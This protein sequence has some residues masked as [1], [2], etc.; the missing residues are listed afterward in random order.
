MK[1]NPIFVGLNIA[2]AKASPGDCNFLPGSWPPVPEFPICISSNGTV[3]SRYE[4]EEWDLTLW[5]GQVLK[6]NFGKPKRKNSTYISPENSSLFKLVIAYW[7]FGPNPVREIRTL[8]G[9]YENIRQ[10]FAYC[11]KSGISANDLYRFPK[12]VESLADNLYP[13]QSNRLL[14]LLHTLWE[15]REHVGISILDDTGI[16]LLRSKIQLHEKSQTAYIPPRIW[17]YQLS[18]LKEFLQDFEHH[19]KDIEACTNYCLHAYVTSAGDMESACTL[20]LPSYYKP[21]ASLN[22]PS[23]NGKLCG[24]QRFGPF[25]KTASRFNIL[26]LLEKWCGNIKSS[27][28]AVLSQYLS[29]A[30]HVGKAYLLNFTLMRIEEV[31][32]LRANCLVLETDKATNETIYLIKGATSKTVEDDQAYWITSPSSQ[33]AIKVMTW[34]SEFRTRCASFNKSLPLAHDDLTNPYLELRPSEPWRRQSRYDY[35]PVVRK[36]PVHYGNFNIKYPKLFDAKELMIQKADFDAALLV[37]PSLDAE[38]FAIGNVWPLSWHQLRRTG[39][40]NMSASGIVG[41]A[42]IQYQLKHVSRAMTRYYG[43]GFYHLD[44]RLNQE[45]SA[46]YVRGMYE[47]IA[48]NFAALGSSNFV[49][50]HGDKRKEQLVE[51][52]SSSSHAALI[53]AAKNGS[54]IYRDI[55]LGSCANPKPCPYGGIDYIGRCGGGDGKPACMDLLIDKNKKSQIQRLGELLS[56]R[57]KNTPEG[58]PLYVSIQYQQIAVGNILNV[59]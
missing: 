23:K 57:I 10:I 37:T 21:F 16:A 36:A 32:S 47:A 54:I 59:I 28:V 42:S 13:S 25:H 9:Q 31:S 20:K 2:S 19:L 33:L 26:D 41:D 8:K 29:M 3:I 46:E 50:P 22:N 5:A 58:S 44:V 43:Q 11:S 24:A 40:V 34:V 39:A 52:I 30:T 48:K 51:I 14:V 27:G 53:K 6:F 18:R 38:R 12:V 55:L 1:I 4:D 49:S 56:Q 15:Q 7:L 45:A 35:A 17:L